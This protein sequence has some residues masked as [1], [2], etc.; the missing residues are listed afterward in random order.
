MAAQWKGE[1]AHIRYGGLATIQQLRVVQ[2]HQRTL[3]LW[4]AIFKLPPCL[5]PALGVIGNGDYSVPPKT[6][7][8]L[9]EFSNINQLEGSASLSRRSTITLTSL[10]PNRTRALPRTQPRSE[11]ERLKG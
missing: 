11:R 5:S 10:E 6:S 9:I 3:L 4:Q 7:L 1:A 2:A 8:N